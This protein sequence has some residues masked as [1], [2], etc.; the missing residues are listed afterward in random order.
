MTDLFTARRDDQ[1]QPMSLANGNV[2]WAGCSEI[3]RSYG[4]TFYFASRFLPPERRRAIHATYAFCRIADDLADRSDDS[5]AAD[6]ALQD[7]ERELD[8]PVHPVA[9]AFAATR[10]R[11]GVPEAPARELLAGV[12]MDLAP[13]RYATW[14]DLSLY[15]YRVAGTVGLMVAPI[16]GCQD[17]DA[18]PHAVALGTAMQLTNILRDIAEDAAQG[19]LYLPLDDLATFGCDPEAILAG[20]PSG[21]FADLLAFEIARARDLYHQAQQ[22]IP[23]L[24]PSGRLTTIAGSVL[25]SSILGKIEDMEYDVFAARARVPTRQKLQTVPSIVTAFVRMSA[26]AAQVSR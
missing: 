24:S 15:C 12:R 22:G 7:W 10:D 2:D 17:E 9:V 6:R 3:A 1:F 13:R 4:Q 21:R 14:D 25:Y 8:T 18:L 26:P 20:R 23:A 19:R 16:L 5:V 11:F